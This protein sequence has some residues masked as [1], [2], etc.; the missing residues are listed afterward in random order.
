MTYSTSANAGGTSNSAILPSVS[1]FGPYSRDTIQRLVDQV[2]VFHLFVVPSS[3]SSAAIFSRNAGG[4]VG[5]KACESVQRFEIELQIGPGV[6]ACN[7]VGESLGRLDLRWMVIPDQFL[8][9]PHCE[10]PPTMFN[11]L[12]SQRFALQETVFTFKNGHGFRS[13]GAGRTFPMTNAGQPALVAAAVGNMVDGFGDFRGLQG[14]FTMCGELTVDR[15]FVGHVVV[16]VLDPEG[17]LRTSNALSPIER[18]QEADPDVTFLGW[19][20]QKG[21]DADQE[22]AFS[23][24]SNGQVRGMNIPTQLK[25]GFVQ[26]ALNGRGEI[27]AEPLNPGAVIGREI[28]FGRG[29]IPGAPDAGTPLSPYQF[30]GVARYTFWDAGGQTVGSITTNVLEGRRFD[31]QLAGAP[32]EPAWRFGFFGPIVCGTGCFEN[33]SGIFYGASGSV[34]TPPPGDHVITHLYMA[35]LNDADGRFRSICGGKGAT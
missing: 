12:L 1:S 24:G 21:T 25:Q 26:S 19:E 30:E 9:R 22:N 28:G 4:C 27:R 17:N 2:S 29:S 32:E 7:V 33:A 34:F 20:A 3:G 14:N 6:S 23:F 10:P 31:M 16:R 15:G 18:G 35:R 13:F 11:P 5:F 8:A